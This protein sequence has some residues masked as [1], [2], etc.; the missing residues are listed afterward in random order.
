MRLLI[1]LVALISVS[2]P[3]SARDITFV[4]W[5]LGWHMSLAEARS[6]IAACG[7]PFV[8]NEEEKLWKPAAS[9]PPEGAKPGWE[10]KWGRDAKI[11]WNITVMAPCDV[12]QANFRIVPVTEAAYE[13]RIAQIRS[14][15]SG[16]L[17]A[18]VLVFQEVTGEQSVRELLPGNGAGY[19]FCAFASHAVQ[20]LVIA[21]KASLGT[22][23]ECE[24]EDALSLP[25]NPDDKRPRPGLSVVLIIDGKRL[26]V[27]TVH[28]KSSCVS[29]W[30]RPPVTRRRASSRAVTSTA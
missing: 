2:I 7:Q 21:W 8:W 23:M 29:R 16:V 19:A 9:P 28:L 24:V 13:K 18:D 14:M 22:G 1:A 11:D 6:W 26:R 3:A 5:N 17:D 30:R 4:T 25:Q 12:Y 27:M 15:I 10:L 20:R